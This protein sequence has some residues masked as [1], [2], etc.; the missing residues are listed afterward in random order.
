MSSKFGTKQEKHTAFVLNVDFKTPIE[1]I[2]NFFG[3]CGEILEI[4]I[5]KDA[6]GIVYKFT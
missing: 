6:N 2:K 5:A 4:R 1:S 3:T